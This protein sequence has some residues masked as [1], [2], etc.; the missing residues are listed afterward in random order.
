MPYPFSYPKVIITRMRGRLK[1]STLIILRKWILV[2]LSLFSTLTQQS[3]C[4]RIMLLQAGTSML[5]VSI[6]G[7]PLYPKPSTRHS[8]Q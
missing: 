4:S 3:E 6:C 1:D 7:T 2:N 8:K 5:G